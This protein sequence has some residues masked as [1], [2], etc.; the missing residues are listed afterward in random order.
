MLA[1]KLKVAVLVALSIA[2]LASRGLVSSGGPEGEKPPAPV[3]AG[4]S[5]STCGGLA[6]GRAGHNRRSSR[7]RRGSRRPARCGG[8]PANRLPRHGRPVGPRRRR[9]GRTADSSCGYRDRSKRRHAQRYRRQY[10]PLGGRIRA[11]FGP[12]WASAPSR[13]PT[14]SELTIRLVEDGPPIE[15]R[16]VDLEGRPV[17]GARVKVEHVWFPTTSGPRM[18]RRRTVRLARGGQDRGVGA[19]GRAS[20]VADDDRHDD[21]PR[22][23]LPPDGDRPRADRRDGHLGADDRHDRALRDDPERARGPHAT[24]EPSEANPSDRLPR[25]PLRYAAAPT[26]PIE[27]D[28]RDKD[29]GRPIAGVRL[30]A[31]VFDER[32]LIPAEGIEATTDAQGHYRLSGLPRA[33]AYRLF[34]EPARVCL[35]PGQPSGRRPTPPHWSRCASTSP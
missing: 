15:G 3:A 27:G 6:R 21:R 1:T 7:P 10:V 9:A 16:I 28:I 20:S 30:H 13:P 4:P 32:S 35:I 5:I 31:A 26:K 33:P 19:P 24:T 18:P 34:V 14:S 22:R 11:G 17:A 25:P 23:P 2:A 8:D 12:G 29:T